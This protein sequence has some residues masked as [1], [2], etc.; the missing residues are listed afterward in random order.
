M[1]PTRI[2]WFLLTFT[3]VHVTDG[4]SVAP[5]SDGLLLNKLPA[6]DKGVEPA[7]RVTQAPCYF[8]HK[9]RNELGKRKAQFRGQAPAHHGRRLRKQVDLCFEP[10]QH[11]FKCYFGVA[12]RVL[13]FLKEKGALSAV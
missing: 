10:I 1:N 8:Q 6:P 2:K 11:V 12:D 5:Q 4:R 9:L 13:V 3:L 7:R